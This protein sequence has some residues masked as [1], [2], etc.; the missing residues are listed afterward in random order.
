MV[1]YLRGYDADFNGILVLWTPEAHAALAHHT[2]RL[3]EE[4][5]EDVAYTAEGKTNERGRENF[6]EWREH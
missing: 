6:G 4:A 2:L 3:G 1:R 5:H